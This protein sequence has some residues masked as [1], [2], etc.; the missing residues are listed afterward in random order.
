MR[1]DVIAGAP[2]AGTLIY[3]TD[4]HS[5]DTERG[6]TDSGSSLL[7]N[8]IQLEVDHEG[9]ALYVWGL[10]PMPAWIAGELHPPVTSPGILQVR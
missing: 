10:A 8:D 7:L 6:P 2:I 9:R 3:R 1:F 4:E 5:F